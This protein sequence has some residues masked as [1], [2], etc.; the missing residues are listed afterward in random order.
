MG[1]VRGVVAL[2][3][4]GVHSMFSFVYF[5]VL[6]LSCVVYLALLSPILLS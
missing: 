3:V 2:V 4:K 6:Y 5:D 1:L